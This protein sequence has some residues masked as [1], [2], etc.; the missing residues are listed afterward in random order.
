MSMKIGVIESRWDRKE[1]DISENTTVQPLFNFLSI[2]RTGVQNEYQYNMVEKLDEFKQALTAMARTN[3][4][5]AVYIAMH[6]NEK[7]LV[8][9]SNDTITQTILVNGLEK[10]E[11]EKKAR[12]L[13]I[14]F[15]ACSFCTEDLAKK[16]FSNCKSVVWIA[17]YLSDA[18]FVCSSALDLM[19]F[20]M[21]IVARKKHGTRELEAIKEVA[22]MLKASAPGLCAITPDRKNEDSGMDFSIFVRGSRRQNGVRNLLQARGIRIQ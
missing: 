15:G 4:V 7:R 19:F 5:T 1:N 22:S 21:L 12:L 17:G 18:D 6:G 10:I 14:H 2:I 9:S 8:L 3:A 20:D 13:G 16:I 11:K